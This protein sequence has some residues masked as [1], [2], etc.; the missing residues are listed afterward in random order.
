MST[1]LN[2]AGMAAVVAAAT[3]LVARLDPDR[4]TNWART[5]T[6]STSTQNPGLSGLTDGDL[7]NQGIA[8][9]EEDQP[10]VLLD[11]TASRVVSRIV[12][13]N[14]ND[15]CYE[16][17]SPLVLE[18]SPDGKSYTRVAQKEGAFHQWDQPIQ[19]Q[20][21][22][23]LRVKLLRKARLVLREVEVY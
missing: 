4:G 8:T 15:C 11:L 13:Y 7:W 22:R 9:G 17:N 5:A 20:P 1:P 10:W 21:A 6:V 14:R 16:H 23:Y 19:R 18:L 12:V 3:L 2:L